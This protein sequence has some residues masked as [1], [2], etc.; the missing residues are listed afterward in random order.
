[1]ICLKLSC[2]FQSTNRSVATRGGS[3]NICGENGRTGPQAETHVASKSVP[4]ML[5]DVCRVP[6]PLGSAEDLLQWVGTK[7]QSTNMVATRMG[8]TTC[9]QRG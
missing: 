1:M 7:I 4:K 2:R 5:P 3:G 6:L 9:W 8:T